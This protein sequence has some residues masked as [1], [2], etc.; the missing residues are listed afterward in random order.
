LPQAD[1]DFDG[2]GD[3]CDLCT[4]AFDPDNAKYIDDDGRLWESNGAYCNG[5]YLCD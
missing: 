5:D 3:V 1:Q 2:L 4:F